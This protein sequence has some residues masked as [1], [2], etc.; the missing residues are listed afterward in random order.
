VEAT[1]KA[2][3]LFKD[4]S[5]KYQESLNY[6]S[7]LSER[8]QAQLIENIYTD[9]ER[10]RGLVDVLMI[11]EDEDFVKVEMQKFNSYLRLFTGEE[12]PEEEQTIDKDLPL[13]SDSIIE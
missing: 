10:Y 8:N 9:I 4:V 5:I 3:K 13:E 7:T 11:Y 12:E 2:R 6:Y 1:E